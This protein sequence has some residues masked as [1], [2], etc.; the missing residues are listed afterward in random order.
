MTLRPAHANV[1]HDGYYW[2][3]P[4]GYD[5]KTGVFWFIR[6]HGDRKIPVAATADNG[7]SP[8]WYST[9]TLRFA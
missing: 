6:Y 4:G 3:E 9:R 8:T 1:F 5:E 2:H 7:S